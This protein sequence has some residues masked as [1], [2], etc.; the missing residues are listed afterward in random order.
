M[1]LNFYRRESPMATSLASINGNCP[2]SF[3]VDMTQV[4]LRFP[5]KLQL[6]TFCKGDIRYDVIENENS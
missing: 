2:T 1:F 5:Q 3:P 4:T 6:P